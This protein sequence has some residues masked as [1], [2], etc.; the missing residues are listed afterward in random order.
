LI[1]C[2]PLPVGENYNT[3]NKEVSYIHYNIKPSPILQEINYKLTGKYM[4]KG[5]IVVVVDQ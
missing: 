3:P 1:H 5:N 4:Q 2:C